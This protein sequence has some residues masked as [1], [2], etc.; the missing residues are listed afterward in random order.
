[1][2]RAACPGAGISRPVTESADFTRPV[3]VASPARNI[4]PGRSVNWSEVQFITNLG[5]SAD[6]Q[7]IT[8]RMSNVR[9]NE[10]FNTVTIFGQ[11]HD[12]HKVHFDY[13]AYLRPFI[14]SINIQVAES[15]QITTTYS[16]ELLYRMYRENTLSRATYNQW[17]ESSTAWNY[18]FQRRPGNRVGHRRLAS[19]STATGKR[20]TTLEQSGR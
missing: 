9:L 16:S 6:K 10:V 8:V 15:P 1:M 20:P 11:L 13:V 18:K 14:R 7:Q 19:A 12:D 5:V 3:I 17:F 2:D 4:L